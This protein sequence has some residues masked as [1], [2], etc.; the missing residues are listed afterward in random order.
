MNIKFQNLKIKGELGIILVFY[1]Y[2]VTS[3][4]L[5]RYF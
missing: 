4:R 3:D 1:F 5:N 2:L